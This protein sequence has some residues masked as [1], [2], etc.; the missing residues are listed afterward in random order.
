M[1][2]GNGD[3]AGVLREV[4]RPD[5]LFFASG[6]SNS[7]ETRESEYQREKD[8]FAQQSRDAQ[9]VYFGTLAVFYSDTR[10]TRHKLEMESLVKECPMYA[11][12]RLGNITWGDNPH[13]LINPLRVRVAEQK[14][15]EILDTTR[16]VINKDEFLHWVKLIPPWNVEMTLT[17]RPMRVKDIVGEYVLK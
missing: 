4:D 17:G 13:T 14:P 15:F 9:I 5:K 1:I 12:V 2:V 6:V 8:L 16:Y 7:Q 3:I 11:L 10:Y